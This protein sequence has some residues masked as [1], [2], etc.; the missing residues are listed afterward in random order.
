MRK[1]IVLLILLIP[2]VLAGCQQKETSTAAGE[3]DLQ[4]VRLLMGF[5]PDIQF[6]PFYVAMERGYFTEQGIDLKIEHM[7][8]NE[9]L[10]LVGAGEVPFVV[11]SGEQV[12]LARA[13]ELPVVYFMAWWQDFPVAIA[14]PAESD[15]ETPA[16]LV[17][18]RVGIPGPYGASYIGYRAILEAVGVD[19][20]QVQLDSIE[21][22][23][24]EALLAGRVDAVVIYANNEPVQ[25]EAQ[26]LPVRVM[27]VADYVE[28][29]S[30][31][32]VT[33]E[34]MLLENPELASK[35]A[36]ATLKGIHDVVEDPELAFEISKAYVEGLDQADQAVLLEVLKRSISFWEAEQP[37]YSNPAAW[38]NMQQ[39]LLEIGLL[40]E[41]LEVERAFSNE[42]LP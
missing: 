16:D 28:L 12:L 35:M 25:L 37:G 38:E 1:M 7:P 10:A 31:G 21:Y 33:S 22:T 5:R 36:Q 29:A 34:Q 39:V 8:E 2:L 4:P 13:Q 9:A 17:G 30:N 24:I 11:A 23:Q 18:K 42:Y 3:G 15:I 14:A 41:A 6:S 26:G 20:S 40:E 19:E 32:L 27:R